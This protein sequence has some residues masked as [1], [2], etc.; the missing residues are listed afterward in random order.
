[1]VE[2]LCIGTILALV[3][4]CAEF[5]SFD[6]PIRAAELE[7][8]APAELSM[9]DSRFGQ[10]DVWINEL[11]AS[12]NIPGAVVAIGRGDR[13]AL[14][15]L[16][17]ERQHNPA[18]EPLTFDTLYDLA[19]VGKVVAL[20]PS[21]ALLV[22]EG[23]LSYHDRVADYL[24]ELAHNGKEK[25]TVYD[26]LTHTSGIQD[27]YS[28]E[29]TPEEIWERICQ[30]KCKAAP[31]EQ[32][33]Y[34]CLGFLIL[35]KLVERIS[36]EPFADFTRNH[37]YLPLGMN[38]TMFRPDPER[39]KRTA[40]T[41][42]FDGHW[43]KGEPNDTR[44]RRMGGGTGNGA[45][46]STLDDM[47]VYASTI[48]HRG[49][50]I[51]SDGQ[52]ARLFSPETF[53]LM[54]GSCPTPAGIRSRGWDKRSDKPNRGALMSP[55]SVGHGGWTGTSIWV[56]PAFDTFVV[57]LSSRLNINPNAPNIYPTVAK[58]ADLAI[59]SIRDEHNETQIRKMVR[60]EVLPLS[61][62]DDFAFLAGKNVALITDSAALENGGTSAVIPLLRA[63]IAVKT[64]FCRD[65]DASEKL[66]ALCAEANQPVP[67]TKRLSDLSRFHLSF[68]ADPAKKTPVHEVNRG[69]EQTKSNVG[70]ITPRRLL[71]PQ[72]NGI[73]TLVFDATTSGAGNDATVTDLGRALQSAADNNLRFVLID[74]P[75]PTGMTQVSGEF[76]PPGSEPTL[77][78]RRL[79]TKYA[80]SLGELAL[81]FASEYRLGL[82]LKV[83]PFAETQITIPGTDAAPVLTSTLPFRDDDSWFRYQ[84]QL[85][86]IY[87]R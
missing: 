60:D 14:R 57:V 87:P 78:F 68:S 35:G 3:I 58:I 44:A 86:L 42:F 71:P 76:S 62:K 18:P 37:L 80:M 40:A 83:V 36:G 38:D 77:S 65:D 19:S 28:Y 54:V 41:Q 66:A 72:I 2:K 50:Y 27:G 49:E 22:D 85:Y 75:N 23:K 52:S 6:K 67:A 70:S 59:D 15:S 25:I 46:F 5:F 84:R 63:G 30:L 10:I 39:C 33:E 11:I 21:I 64:V 32:F 34:S 47:A 56:D 31:G 82:A 53:A 55:Q 13:L 51:T 79:P 9:D 81:M 73:D 17:G 20:A 43:I 45:S 7:Q 48:L 12:E 69:I 61:A 24:P 8:T 4:V 29:G 74:R 1:M 16:W 26:F